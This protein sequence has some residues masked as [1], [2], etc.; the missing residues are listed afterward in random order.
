MAGPATVS[1]TGGSFKIEKEL[2]RTPLRQDNAPA[3][4][5]DHCWGNFS[6]SHFAPCK[7][8]RPILE[9]QNGAV[10]MGQNEKRAT[11]ESQQVLLDPKG[12][13]LDA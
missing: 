9:S 12:L 11:R 10:L 2:E 7:V 1:Q 6:D 5:D 4:H 3:T 13:A 8:M